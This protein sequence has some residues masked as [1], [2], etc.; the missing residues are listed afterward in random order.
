MSVSVASSEDRSVRTPHVAKNAAA[1]AAYQRIRIRERERDRKRE[2]EN[3]RERR[4]PIENIRSI[5]QE[6]HMCPFRHVAKRHHTTGSC[7]NLCRSRQGGR[8]A[9]N[10]SPP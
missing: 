3:Q 9:I 5:R 6:A 4:F 8:A 10:H 1:P 2:R 7:L